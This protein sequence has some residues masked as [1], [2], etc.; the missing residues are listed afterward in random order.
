MLIIILVVFFT[1]SYY[2][3]LSFIENLQNGEARV[4]KQSKYTA[5]ACQAIAMIS[6]GIFLFKAL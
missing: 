5:V 6:L 2:F 1:L 4:A 3:K